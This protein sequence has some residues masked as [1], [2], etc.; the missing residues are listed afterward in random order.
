[1]EGS[2]GLVDIIAATANSSFLTKAF[3]LLCQV[4]TSG[5]FP[6]DDGMKVM[7]W[8]EDTLVRYMDNSIQTIMNYLIY[9][10]RQKEESSQ[11]NLCTLG[12][13]SPLQPISIKI[14]PQNEH[15]LLQLVTH[16]KGYQRY[17]ANTKTTHPIHFISNINKLSMFN[18]LSTIL[19]DTIKPEQ[20]SPTSLVYS[21]LSVKGNR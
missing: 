8:N 2:K 16:T 4:Q 17:L 11:S 14:T 10:N 20:I 1:M 9:K 19:T 12:I 21:I 6:E 18:Y 13:Q 7:K 15:H 5:T 3:E